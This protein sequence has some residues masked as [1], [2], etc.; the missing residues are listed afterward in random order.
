M[1]PHN[2]SVHS[3]YESSVINPAD[4]KDP[5]KVG[6]LFEAMFYRML[7][8]QV[9]DSEMTE[10]FFSGFQSEQIQEM[11]DDELANSLASEGQLGISN[12]ITDYLA[13]Q[14]ATELS[15]LVKD[16]G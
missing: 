3:F 16:R 5:R 8:K 14:D 12:L 11:R 1:V 4:R 13:K 6:A 10:P 15:G 9:R 7:F 2:S